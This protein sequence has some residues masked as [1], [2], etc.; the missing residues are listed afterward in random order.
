MVFS[1]CARETA[2]EV[3]ARGAIERTLSAHR[4]RPVDPGLRLE[5][6]RVLDA[7]GDHAQAR[8]ELAALATISD[9]SNPIAAEARRLFSLAKAGKLATMRDCGFLPM[10][11]YPR[12]FVKLV[13]DFITG[14]QETPNHRAILRF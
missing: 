9:S 7:L 2:R 1:V 6:A 13:E 4:A 3:E 10:L 11:E 14:R 8:T 5:Y 12:Q